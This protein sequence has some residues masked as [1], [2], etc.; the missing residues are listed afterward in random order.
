MRGAKVLE[1]YD[2]RLLIY[3]GILRNVA[4]SIRHQV[5]AN[6]IVAVGSCLQSII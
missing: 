3:I 5:L 2:R 4:I 1:D 6:I